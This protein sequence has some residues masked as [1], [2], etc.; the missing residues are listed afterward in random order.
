MHPNATL[1]LLHQYTGSDMGQYG[2][3]G[4]KRPELFVLEQILNAK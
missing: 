1:M 3:E 2:F 4:D